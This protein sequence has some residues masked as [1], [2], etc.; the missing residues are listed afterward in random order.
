[1]SLLFK[2]PIINV[3]IPYEPEEKLG[4]AYN[5]IMQESAREWNLLL[6]WDVLLLNPH[7]YGI[8]QRA[9]LYL[10]KASR[11]AGI[12]TAMTNIS[13]SVVQKSHNCPRTK[14]IGHHKQWAIS[15]YQRHKE[16]IREVEPPYKFAGYFM[17]VNKS[18]WSASGGFLDEYYADYSYCRQLRR[19][20]FKLYILP[21]LYVYHATEIPQETVFL[22]N[23][24]NREMA[25]VI[26]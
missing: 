5:R 26:A 13:P 9:I 6:D 8:C 15:L 14:D 2:E 11:P 16:T 24:D 20:G 3:Y 12:I 21:G 19:H 18:A 4:A 7:W 10:E 17:L 25:G 1:M 23:T 22:D